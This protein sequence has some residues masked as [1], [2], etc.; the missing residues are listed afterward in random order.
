MAESIARNPFNGT[1]NQTL[2]FADPMVGLVIFNESSTAS[3][4][5]TAGTFTAVVRPGGAFDE[6]INPFTKL[7]ITTTSG[8]YNGYCRANQ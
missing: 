1:G 4:T 3:L 7:M 8:D 6:R 2:N 5:F